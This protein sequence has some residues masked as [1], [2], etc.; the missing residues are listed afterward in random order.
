MP[1]IRS[2]LWNSLSNIDVLDYIMCLFA[3]VNFSKTNDN[4]VAQQS[5]TYL[6]YFVQLS[7]VSQIEF[8]STFDISRWK[9]IQ[10]ILQ[11]YPNVI[12]LI[13]GSRL[14]VLSELIDNPSLIPIFKQ[15]KMVKSITKKIYFPSNLASKLVQR[16]PSLIHIELQDLF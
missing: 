13:I 11:A 1:I 9:D 12:N 15:I 8:G 16:F 14:L 5:V 3:L 7:H 10:F 6:S 2:S 4:N